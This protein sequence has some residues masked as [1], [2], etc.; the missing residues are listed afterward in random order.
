MSNFYEL[1]LSLIL[2]LLLFFLFLISYVFFSGVSLC[3][4]NVLMYECGFNSKFSSRNIFSL[5]FYIFMLIFIVFDAEI[6][7]VFPL[8]VSYLSVIMNVCVVIFLIFL[9][10]I[11]LIYEWYDGSLCWNI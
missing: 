8:I 7:F 10:F 9:I 1:C 2:F 11:S 4:N 5:H 6:V 3:M